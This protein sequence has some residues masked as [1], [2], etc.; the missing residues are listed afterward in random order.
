MWRVTLFAGLALA[1]VLAWCR[2][3][4]ADPAGPTLHPHVTKEALQ[5]YPRQRPTNAV[6]FAGHWYKVFPQKVCWHVARAACEQMG[7]YLVCIETAEEQAF[8]AGLAEGRYYYLGA[9]DEAQ[10][11]DWRW[12]NGAKWDY[13]SWFS[14]Q[15]NNYRSNEHWLATYTGGKWVDVADEGTGFWMPKGFICEWEK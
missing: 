4:T 13:T 15:P 10:E 8:I 3:L 2:P 11:G 1:L 12:V 9:T 14:G 5:A 7:G 6:E